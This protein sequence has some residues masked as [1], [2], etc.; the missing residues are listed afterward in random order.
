MGIE[1]T[2]P[3]DEGPGSAMEFLIESRRDPPGDKVKDM[4]RGFGG[5][6]IPVAKL[7]GLL[8]GKK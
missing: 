8:L 6:V 7:V 3:N 5:E 4:Q 1:E 2:E